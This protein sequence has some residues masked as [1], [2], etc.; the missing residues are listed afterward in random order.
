M[1]STQHS[2]LLATGQVCRAHNF[3][4]D[5]HM[6]AGAVCTI[7]CAVREVGFVVRAAP[8][9]VLALMRFPRPVLLAHAQCSVARVGLVCGSRQES[10]CLNITLANPV[11]T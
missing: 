2:A 10:H 5:V 8:P 3:T 11:A 9:L 1:N 7:A 4:R 6:V